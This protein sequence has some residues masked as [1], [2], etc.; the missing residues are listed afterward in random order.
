VLKNSLQHKQVSG[1]IIPPAIIEELKHVI[2][3]DKLT[4]SEITATTPSGKKINLQDLN[5][6]LT[7]TYKNSNET[8]VLED[9][10]FEK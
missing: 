8:G 7:G 6:I 2:N 3:E 5:F 9:E 4:L 1:Y 10:L